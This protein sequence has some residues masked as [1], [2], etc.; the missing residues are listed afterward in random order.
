MKHITTKRKTW[1]KVLEES[2]K[3][4]LLPVAHDALTA[5]LIEMA[6]FDAYQIG[7]YAL[8]G[9]TH[10]IPDVDLEKFGEK[11]LS[12]QDIL[13]ASPLPFM[14]DIDDGYGDVK[15]VTRTISEY[16]HMG[17][18]ATFMEDQQPPK[19]CGH[20]DDK[21]IV[22]PEFMEQKIR[23]AL[24]ARGENE[25][26]ILART[27]A[28]GPEGLDSAIKRAERYLK[29]GADG[30]YLEGPTS[31][32]QLEQIGK[33]FKDIPL[34]TSV[35]ENGGKTPWLSPQDFADLGFDMILYP[36]TVIFQVAYATQQALKRLKNGEPLPK[37]K[38]ENM[39]SFL[40]IVDLQYW[41]EIEKKFEG[42]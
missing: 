1:K 41:A 28:I 24:A 11:K 35:L 27:D 34:A 42:K 22:A 29:A 2:T 19:K 5:R 7:G 18:S 3:P 9:A 37:D 21:K 36:T 12:V 32:E 20:M 40:N 13:T 15:N 23:A 25:L 17:A 10:A 39:D 26:F 8:S 33:V 38:A 6:G 14:I 4:V 30:V 16:I 31:V